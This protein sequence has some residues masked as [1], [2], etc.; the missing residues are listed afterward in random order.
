M[1]E[2]AWTYPARYPALATLVSC[3]ELE[4]MTRQGT[5]VAERFEA[6][7]C[8]F[9][10]RFRFQGRQK[11]RYIGIDSAF[12]E[13]VRSELAS[14]QHAHRSCRAFRNAARR[15]RVRC[16]ETKKELEPIL[17][18]TEFYFYG[19]EVRRSRNI[20]KS[21]ET[22]SQKRLVMED[23]RDDD[24]R[25]EVD[26]EAGGGLRKQLNAVIATAIE[27]ENPRQAVARFAT[28][29]LMAVTAELADDVESR[30]RENPLTLRELRKDAAPI[31]HCLAAISRQAA[32]FAQLD[33]D[34]D[35]KE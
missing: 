20:R 22:H 23:I 28:A 15:A 26:G 18:G 4:A 25:H 19:W 31:L 2:E 35:A 9:K 11:V 27:L 3:Q 14:L 33:R 34:F 32:R 8:R 21:V 6:H 7:K 12:A 10:L 1:T 16:R 29:K 24:E 17:A 30:L 5:V 13:R